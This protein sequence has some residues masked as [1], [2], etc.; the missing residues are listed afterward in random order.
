MVN[1]GKDIKTANMSGEMDGFGNVAYQLEVDPD[2]DIPDNEAF[3]GQ[4]GTPGFGEWEEEEEQITPEF[5][6]DESIKGGTPEFEEDQGMKRSRPGFYSDNGEGSSDEGPYSTHIGLHDIKIPNDDVD[7]A[8]NLSQVDGP[9]VSDDNSGTDVDKE[10][11][12][13]SADEF[14]SKR[15]A[16][17]K[18]KEIP[19]KGRIAKSWDEWVS[20]MDDIKYYLQYGTKRPRKEGW[21]TN[22]WKGVKKTAHKKYK[23]DGT[24]L[25]FQKKGTWVEVLTDRKETKLMMEKMHNENGDL[26]HDPAH[27]GR[28]FLRQILGSRFEW[29]RMTIDID[30][31]K[32]SCLICARAHGH[33]LKKGKLLKSIEIDVLQIT[34]PSLLF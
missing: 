30:N 7:E 27:L 1:P 24:H 15:P 5:Q 8:A 18:N 3:Q 13:S 10:D 28:N 26:I 23:M 31:F 22:Q 4:G 11:S 17:Q 25:M 16:K 12:G 21:T 32:A 9:T 33:H 29:T 2:E 34:F 14:A 20:K 6:E 19:G